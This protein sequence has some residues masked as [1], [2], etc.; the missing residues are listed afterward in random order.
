M[1]YPKQRTDGGYP[2]PLSIQEEIL[3][4]CNH[5]QSPDTYFLL[6]YAALNTLFLKVQYTDHQVA[7]LR[8]R[9]RV[10][11]DNGETGIACNFS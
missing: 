8:D 7:G 5:Q 6:L 4:F 10:Q 1:I 11:E 2:E 3:E 9:I